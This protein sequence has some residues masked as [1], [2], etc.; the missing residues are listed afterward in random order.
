VTTT[1]KPPS[2]P[3][4]SLATALF[5][6]VLAVQFLALY[7]PRVAVEQP[8][9]VADK[10][11]HVLLFAAPAAA[12]LL[13]GLRPAYLLG[14][15]ALHAP[16]SELLQHTILPHRTGDPLDALADLVGVALGAAAGV[17]WARLRRW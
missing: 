4:L 13:A 8:F 6:V 16:V 15:L 10:A 12:G 11:V 3:R 7:W 9:S 2:R 1:A 5:A 17:V 14:L